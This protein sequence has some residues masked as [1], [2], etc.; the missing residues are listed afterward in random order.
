LQAQHSDTIKNQNPVP[1]ESIDE[2]VISASRFNQIRLKTPDAIELLDKKP[3]EQH[4]MRTVPEALALSSGLFIQKTNY[5]GGSPFIRGL[6]GNQTLLLIDGIRLSNSTTRY[7]PNQYLNTIDVFGIEKIEV[8]RGNG[9]VQYGSD[10]IGGTIQV[11]SHELYFEE[12]PK[13]SSQILSRFGTNK[14]EKSLHAQLE[15]SNR[16]M[17]IDGEVSWRNFGDLIGGDTTGKQSPSGYHEFDYQFK[18]KL[19]ISENSFFTMA[20]QHVHQSNVPVY[21]KIVLENYDLNE[22]NPQDRQLAYIRLNQKLNR[23]IFNSLVL[24]ASIQHSEEGRQSHKVGSDIFRYEND[25]VRTISF[26]ADLLSSSK[27]IWSANTGFEIYNDLVKSKKTDVNTIN[28]TEELNRGL[29]PNGSEMIS[30]AA[31]SIHT[32]DFTNWNV[33]AGA[34]YN[35]YLIKVNDDVLGTTKLN[36]SALI[37]NFGVSRKLNQSSIVFISL[38][39]GFR[40]PNMDDLGTLGIVDFRYETPNLNLKPEKSFQ[41]QLGYKLLN[42]SLKAEI[43]IYRNELYNLITRNRIGTDSIDSYPVYQK[44]NND[45]T[46][47]QGFES[48]L[49]Y[50]LNLKWI[51]NGNI[52]Y[53]FGE[54][55]TRKEPVRRIPPVFGSLSIEFNNNTW[56]LNLE[57]QAASKQ[58]R[59]ANGDI[60]DN[61]IPNGGTP[62]WN[63]FNIN[64]EYTYK[65]ITID[66]NLKNLFNIDYRYH[67][68]GINGYG[69]SAFVGLKF[70]F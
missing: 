59:L 8:L 63:I 45:R 48:V 30:M 38:N 44:E 14:M 34:R 49:N 51:L 7:G 33:S 11:F 46:Y 60:D 70:N 68:S 32:F 52:C 53:T 1:T 54:N 16:N 27:K 66:L 19:K 9:S 57:W 2:V 62:A 17:A 21:H 29:Y 18:S 20:F 24:T 58:N 4:Q 39:S 26:S 35:F 10:A 47:I 37:G 5:G 41:Y 43:Y 3:I 15:F 22:M 36:P 67:G 65:F 69:R 25:Q 6:T 56:W 50:K 55:I 61:R 31:F 23:P 28:N 42:Q 64:A 13:W 12:K 40:A